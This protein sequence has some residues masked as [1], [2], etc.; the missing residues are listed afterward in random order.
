[1]TRDVLQ[2]LLRQRPFVPIEL[3]LS[4]G[5]KKTVE[6]PELAGLAR[7]TLWLFSPQNDRTLTVTLHHIVSAEPLRELLAPQRIGE[8][9]LRAAALGEA[10]S[11]HSR[12][13]SV[14][15]LNRL[16][17]IHRMR[18]A[19]NVEP[20]L[21][22]RNAE[23]GEHRRS[24]VFDGDHVVGRVGAERVGAADDLAAV[25]TRRRRRSTSSP[26]PSDRGRRLC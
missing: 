25:D 17:P 11:A 21:V 8:L 16:R 1:M 2:D 4:T 12:P 26:V 19:V 6:H 20:L 9:T 18:A 15:P 10:H 13:L 22:A 3:T 7:S 24:D 23:R 14:K 5:E